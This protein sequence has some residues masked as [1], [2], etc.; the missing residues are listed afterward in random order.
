[1]LRYQDYIKES[2]DESSYEEGE[3]VIF[4]S[5]RTYYKNFDG[6]TCKINHVYGDDEYQLLMP[7][8]STITAS[9]NEISRSGDEPKKITTADVIE[10]QFEPKSNRITIGTDENGKMRIVNPNQPTEEK[11]EEKF[12][13]GQRVLV[14][15]NTGRITFKDRKGTILRVGDDLQIE[16]DDDDSK[17]FSK[18]VMMIDRSMVTPLDEPDRTIIGVGDK[19]ECIDNTS[20]FFKQKGT[21]TRT[22]PDGDL[23]CDYPDRKSQILMKQHQIKVTEPAKSTN[24][25][26]TTTPVKTTTSIPVNGPVKTEEEED[27]EDSVTVTRKETFKKADLLEF[28]WEDFFDA[29]KT[30]TKD[31]MLAN[32]KK[33][34]DAVDAKV[35]NEL[36]LI[37]M[38]KAL[39]TAEIVEQYF[40]F[41]TAKVA[42]ELP[43]FRTVE[44]IENEDLLST[45]TKIRA[46]ESK[47]LTKKYSFDQGIIAYW[48]FKDAVIFK[49]I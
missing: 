21:I 13:K 40:D 14:S 30:I 45:K 3:D 27:D 1:M 42:K 46:S 34:Q 26:K 16:F 19:I 15:G 39:R 2:R 11:K 49:T 17:N 36:K 35:G 4:T 6:K 7:G 5:S 48:K 33:Y 47:E 25:F 18:I 9:S 24:D 10:N 20:D 29:E 44:V 23:M 31:D 28:S 8:G 41:L 32:K 22:W 43:V 37:F 12:K 38:E